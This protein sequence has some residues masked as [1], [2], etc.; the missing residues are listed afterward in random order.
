MARKVDS[1]RSVLLNLSQVLTEKALDLRE[2]ASTTSTS[3]LEEP[4]KDVT[5]G[6]YVTAHT[7][8][9]DILVDLLLRAERL[10]RGLKPLKQK[11]KRKREADKDVDSDSDSILVSCAYLVAR[12]HYNNFLCIIDISCSYGANQERFISQKQQ[13]L[14]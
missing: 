13:S 9:S 5:D 10:R 14:H 1:P 12:Q 4:E 8:L 11:L 3:R 6:K 2:M 7:A